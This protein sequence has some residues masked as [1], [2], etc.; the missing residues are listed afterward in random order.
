MRGAARRDVALDRQQRVVAVGAGEDAEHV[1]DAR[2]RRPACS[3]A[4]M[5]LSKVGASGPTGDGGDLGVVLGE[6]ALEGRHE[7][8]GLD[9]AER[10]R[11]EGAVQFFEERIG[12]GGEVGGWTV[13]SVMPGIWWLARGVAP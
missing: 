1:V 6:G 2:Q 11:A 8:L 5:V 12:G 13:R 4:T 3:S 10:R 7:M 9:A